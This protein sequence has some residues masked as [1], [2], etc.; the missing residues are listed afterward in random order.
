MN[1]IMCHVNYSHLTLKK[2]LS[3]LNR[4]EV[5]KK[6]SISSDFVSSERDNIKFVIYLVGAEHSLI[7]FLVIRVSTGRFLLPRYCRSV[8]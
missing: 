8:V 7:C 3:M 2:S 5:E 1:K 6:A 4:S